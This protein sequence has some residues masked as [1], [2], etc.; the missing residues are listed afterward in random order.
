MQYPKRAGLLPK[1]LPVNHYNRCRSSVKVVKQVRI[2]ADASG[3][4][5]PAAIRLK[6]W[7]VG[8]SATATR[9]AEMVRCELGLPAVDRIAFSAGEVKLLWLVVRMKYAALGAKRASAARQRFGYVAVDT[10]SNLP[11]MAAS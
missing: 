3:R 9:S 1:I 11:A 10:K 7:G 4:P 8:E 2:H 5:I 6:S